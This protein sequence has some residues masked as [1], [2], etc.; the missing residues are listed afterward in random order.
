[1]SEELKK[2]QEQLKEARHILEMVFLHEHI[3][4]TCHGFGVVNAAPMGMFAVAGGD[5]CPDC[6][7]NGGT[8]SQRANK[9]LKELG[10]THPDLK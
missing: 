6:P 8:S 10:C 5:P 4:E 2:A 9:L 1:M 7:K 3:C